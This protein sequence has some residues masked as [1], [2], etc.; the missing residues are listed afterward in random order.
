[1]KVLYINMLIRSQK[2]AKKLY[3]F[4]LYQISAPFKEILF[5]KFA[6]SVACNQKALTYNAKKKLQNVQK[7]KFD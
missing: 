6:S 2:M 7:L 3:L 4:V 5:S 1:M